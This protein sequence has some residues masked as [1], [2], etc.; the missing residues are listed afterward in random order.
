M[1]PNKILLLQV[2]SWSGVPKHIN[3]NKYVKCL[4]MAE[5]RLY[6]GCTGYSIQVNTSGR[7]DFGSR[8]H[9]TNIT[10]TEYS[11]THI[12]PSIILKFWGKWQEVD[13]CKSTTNT[14]YSGARKLLGKQ[15]IYSLRIHDGLLYAGGSSVDGTA[16]KVLCFSGN[17][18]IWT[19]SVTKLI[20]FMF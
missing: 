2:Y 16:G 17:V 7:F 3:F 15:T 20:N 10:Q 8:F 19:Y 5:D 12:Y 6:C 4:D 13:L 11:L 9:Q 1:V 18:D 14:F